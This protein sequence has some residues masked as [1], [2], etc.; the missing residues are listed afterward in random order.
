MNSIDYIYFVAKLIEVI[1]VLK[2]IVQ[3][4]SLHLTCRYL[5]RSIPQIYHK[6]KVHFH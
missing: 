1:Y 4:I 6:T 2:E 3:Q 5:S